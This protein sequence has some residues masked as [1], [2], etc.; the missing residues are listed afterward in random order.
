VDQHL[1]VYSDGSARLSDISNIEAPRVE[2]AY[3]GPEAVSDLCLHIERWGGMLGCDATVR[4][5]DVPLHT[6]T[7]LKGGPDARAHTF[8][9]WVPEG[10]ELA[11]EQLLGQFLAD[12]F[13]G[14]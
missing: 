5:M 6:L 10:S 9:W 7:L 8:S 12:N 11:I 4:V 14:G 3:P 13:P 2:L 1:T